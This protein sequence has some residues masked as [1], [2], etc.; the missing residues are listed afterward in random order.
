L[1]D[2][3]GSRLVPVFVQQYVNNLKDGY[4]H[5]PFANYYWNVALGISYTTGNW[6]IGDS[7]EQSGA[8]KF[9]TRKHKRMILERIREKTEK[10]RTSKNII[11]LF[12]FSVMLFADHLWL[13][14]V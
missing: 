12:R 5:D 11:I 3:H 6:Q 2:S 14:V 10:L 4:S 8:M 1:L 13:R 7:S 9:H